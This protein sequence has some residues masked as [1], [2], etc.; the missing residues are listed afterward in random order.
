MDDFQ[1]LIDLHLNNDRQGPGGDR[2]TQQAM[3]IAC[4]H[5][6]GPL[7]IADI[8]C[9]T[10]ASTLTL[11]R[12]LDASVTAVDFLPEFVTGHFSRLCRISCPEMA[13][14]KRQRR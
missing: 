1:L 11:A 4:L 9:G 5:Q 8:G 6:S 7:R 13:I 12:S 3:E 2:E 10:S 14:P